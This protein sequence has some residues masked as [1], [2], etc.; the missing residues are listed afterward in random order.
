MM[1]RDEILAMVTAQLRCLPE[2][3]NITLHGSLEI[4][5]PDRY[6]D[7]DLKINVS[8]SDNGRFM[9]ELPPQ[10]QA[11]CRLLPLKSRGK[12]AETTCEIHILGETK[13]SIV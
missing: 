1:T 2:V 13:H 6:S 4:G 5:H 11:R 12:K 10:S 8:G 9:L 3:R 7:I